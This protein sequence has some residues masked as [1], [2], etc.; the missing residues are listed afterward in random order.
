MEILTAGTSA[1]DDPAAE[2]WK[3]DLRLTVSFLR[4]HG[5]DA[6]YVYVASPQEGGLSSLVEAAHPRAIFLELSEEN[7]KPVLLA[8]K[9]LGQRFLEIPVLLGGIPA[10]LDAESVFD[11]CEQATF[12]VEG[13]R[14]LTL[15]ETVERLRGHEPLDGIPGLRTCEARNPPR[16]LLPDL[17]VLGSIVYDGLPEM[18][19]SYSAGDRTAFLRSSRGCYGTCSF[20]GIPGFYRRS[21]GAP[22]RGRSP[23]VV[24]DEIE[25][26]ISAFGIRRFVFE[27]D[28]F[29]GPG[30]AG[31][32][33]ARG[34]ASEIARRK[35]GIEYFV[36]CRLNDVDAATMSALKASGLSGIGVSVESANQE[37]LDL[38]KKGIKATAIY[39]KLRLLEE[40]Q[41]RCEVNMIFFDPRVTLAGVRKNLE[42]LDYVRRSE[43]LSYSDAFPFTELQAFPWSP[44]SRSL[45]AEGLLEGDGPMCRFKDPLV[46]VLAGLVRRL[47][48]RMPI[49]FK[50]RL[51]F[52][53]ADSD[54]PH[55]AATAIL[56]VAA[57]MRHWAG[58]TVMPRFV[59]EACDILEKDPD[60]VTRQF[61]LLEERFDEAI[62]FLRILEDRVA[63]LSGMESERPTMI[64]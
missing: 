62:E 35:L 56:R 8:V 54:L 17:D 1:Y 43:Y 2:E 6:G 42:L 57:G 31:R 48:K 15:L 49:V 9:E 32:E 4:R 13:E 16:P 44:V 26:L 25:G 45:R 29:M 21:P 58:L 28:D 64:R 53:K 39:P 10:T 52:E 61:A 3:P 36:C 59:A 51:L 41:I 27:D 55:D 37:S 19:S 30:A 46:S 38:L 20:C 5:A 34:I 24:V 63:G 40:L 33:R 23:K 7:R 11:Q 50:K 47:Q 60:D 18:L 14:E 12:L 22:W